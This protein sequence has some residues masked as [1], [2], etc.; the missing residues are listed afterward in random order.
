MRPT[1]H[2]SVAEAA[3]RWRLPQ[4]SL[5]EEIAAGRLHARLRAGTSRGM[6]LTDAEMERWIAEDFPVAAPRRGAWRG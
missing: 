3:R 4:R 2:Y 6:R 1:T 5:Y